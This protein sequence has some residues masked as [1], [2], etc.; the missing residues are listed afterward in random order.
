M[1]IL[2]VC[3]GNI[4]R[5]PLAEGVLRHKIEQAGLDWE[6]DSAGT[7]GYHAGSPPHPLSCEV[8]LD[9]GIDIRG[10]RARAFEPA[11]MDRFDLIYAMD[12]SVRDDIR[13]IAADRYQ[14]GRTR[15][16]L[17][18]IDPDRYEDL[19]DPYN[20]PREA[21]EETFRLVEQA[22]DCI[23]SLH[24]APGTTPRS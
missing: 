17:Q 13:H 24:S 7:I 6:V 21:F 20:R 8:A 9:Q 10:Q 11:D 15:L 23:L 19:E 16:L 1:R 14:E 5:S 4:C 12:R 3:L 22:C 2:M 18:E